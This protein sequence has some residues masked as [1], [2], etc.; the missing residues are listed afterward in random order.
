[1][2]LRDT[3]EA[4][5]WLEAFPEYQRERARRLLDSLNLVS[6]DAFVTTTRRLIAQATNGLAGPIAIFAAREVADG[7]QYFPDK[8]RIPTIIR[9]RPGSEA[10]IAQ[11]VTQTSRE[12][13]ARFLN[14]PP[15]MKMRSDACRHI[16]I[17]EDMVGTGSRVA[18]FIASILAHKTVRSWHSFRWIEFHIIAYA[19]G[20][21]A[22][23]LIRRALKSRHSKHEAAVKFWRHT[24]P[25]VGN[26]LWPGP[27]R[28]SLEVLAEHR[29]QALKIPRYYRKGFGDLMANIVFA[30]GCPNNAPGIL[31]WG[32][33]PD[34]PAL[35]PHRVVPVSLLPAF[36]NESP[37]ITDEARLRALMAED[38]VNS[39]VLNLTSEKGRSVLVLLAALRRKIRRVERLQEATGFS[40]HK[41]KL[42][43]Q[44]CQEAGWVDAERFLTARGLAEVQGA[45]RSR[46]TPFSAPAFANTYYF[47]KSLKPARGQV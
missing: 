12:A 26:T 46:R 31:W 36:N 43:L 3:P 27:L 18:K 14:H 4:N 28:E 13:P 10:T 1:M 42:I 9:G 44:H 2:L 34:W 41:L 6:P 19:I 16:F 39:G 37:R 45:E 33:N 25:V 32:E 24:R 30:H 22:E 5:V 21:E 20:M 29:G 35:F 40:P 17:V 38:I 15:I 47:P 8:K 11:I 23:S 7:E